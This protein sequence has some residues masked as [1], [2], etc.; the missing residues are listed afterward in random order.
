MRDANRNSNQSPT[1]PLFETNWRLGVGSNDGAQVRSIRAQSPPP[2]QFLLFVTRFDSRVARLAEDLA[3]LVV[4][5]ETGC[6]GDFVREAIRRHGLTDK[7]FEV[8]VERALIGMIQFL[9][10]R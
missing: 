5:I 6:P 10:E 8:S 3:L 9:G 4:S 2:F 1:G 7:R